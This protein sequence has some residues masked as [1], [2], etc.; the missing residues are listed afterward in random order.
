MLN[1]RKMVDIYHQHGKLTGMSDRHLTLHT[2]ENKVKRQ[3]TSG[4][5]NVGMVWLTGLD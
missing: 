2:F 4:I 5:G 1:L 3:P